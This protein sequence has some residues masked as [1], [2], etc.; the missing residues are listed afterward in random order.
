VIVGP[1]EYLVIAGDVATSEIMGDVVLPTDLGF[2]GSDLVEL[3]CGGT[4]IDVVDWTT[5]DFPAEMEEV[6]IQLDDGL[7]DAVSND[8]LTGWCLTPDG[9]TYGSMGR[10]GTPGEANPPCPCPAVSSGL[11]LNEIDYDQSGSDDA[12]FVEIVN[13]SG[14]DL[15]LCD[16]DVVF[17]NGSGGAEY[18]R[19]ALTG[20]VAMDGFVV[21]VGNGSTV[22]PTDPTYETSGGIQNGTDGVALVS[23]STGDVIDFITYDGTFDATE[24]PAGVPTSLNVSIGADPASGDDSLIRC[25]TSGDPS[26][27]WAVSA[28]STSPGAANSCP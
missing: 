14:A 10:R 15:A 24:L 2:G 20:T 16:V 21:V 18:A 8:D 19:I 27:D 6:S 13:T 26:A 25:G 22:T 23:S 28:S 4:S 5:D 12:E 11:L 1:G 9:S 17:Y 3:T 7:E